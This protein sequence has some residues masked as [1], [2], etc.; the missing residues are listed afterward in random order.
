MFVVC[1]KYRKAGYILLTC[2][3][4]AHVTG[5][6]EAVSSGQD[7][8]GEDGGASSGKPSGSLSDWPGGV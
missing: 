4:C 1:D 7:P 5:E 2:C 6:W 8:V 3:Q